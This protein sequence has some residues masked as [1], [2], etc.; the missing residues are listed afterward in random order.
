MLLTVDKIHRHLYCQPLFTYKCQP[1]RQ[2]RRYCNLCQPLSTSVKFTAN[3]SA[4]FNVNFVN[5]F[6]INPNVRLHLRDEMSTHCTVCTYERRCHPIVPE[7]RDVNKLHLL[8][9]MS[10][11]CTQLGEISTVWARCR[12]LGEV[13]TIG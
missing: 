3:F 4:K 11:D 6:N 10:S 12:Q 13:L 9:G 5:K 7:K 8:D 1:R 2:P